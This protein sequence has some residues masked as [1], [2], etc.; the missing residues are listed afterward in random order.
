M[1]VLYAIGSKFAGGGIGT[2]AYHGVRGLYRHGMLRRVLCGAYRRTEIPPSLIRAMGLPD[3]VLRKLAVFDSSG[4]LWYFQSVLFDNWAAR[5]LEVAA[6]FHVWGNFGLRAMQRAKEM[7][8]VTV[9]QRAS[10]H[11]R[12]QAR[13]LAEEYARWG[14]RWTTPGVALQRALAEIAIADY[15]LIPSD[16]VRGT[17]IAEG[18]SEAKL[19]Q[20]PFGADVERF[21]PAPGREPHPFRTLF[22][23]QVSLRKGVPYL[24][25]AWRRL[26]WCDAELWLAGAVAPDV[27]PILQRYGT[28]AGV[29]FLGHA[30][31]PVSLYQRAD[32]FVFPT[33]EEGS[34]LVTYEALACGLPVATTPNAGSVVRDGVDGFIVPIRDVE[35]LAT[36]LER[37]RADERL[38]RE[39]GRAAR[40]RAEAFPWEEYGDRLAASLAELER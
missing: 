13:L 37:L 9:L 27:R 20:I 32:V 39:L 12:Y 5:H 40:S 30:S 38:R 25:E 6:L 35:A 34:A 17:F 19:L 29:R 16:F 15:V 14:L 31:D 3:R 36:A 4:W 10:A 26:G 22:V 21:Q 28:L 23:G 8:M 33:I 18:V 24:L 7:G 2:T 11:P 1:S